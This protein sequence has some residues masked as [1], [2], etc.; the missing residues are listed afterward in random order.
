VNV[1]HI[2]GEGTGLFWVDE[3]MQLHKH[4]A[5]VVGTFTNRYIHNPSNHAFLGPHVIDTKGNVRTIEALKGHRLTATMDHLT[6]PQNRVYM[7]AMEGEFYE[8][9]VH[10]LEARQRFDLVKELDIPK[11]VQPHLKSAYTDDGRA[12]VWRT[13]PAAKAIISARRPLDGWPVGR[14]AVHD[15][16]VEA[17]CRGLRQERN[18]LCFR[19]SDPGDWMG[20]G[21]RTPEGVD[22]GD[23]A[24]VSP[25]ESR[26]GV[27]SRLEHGMDA[28][29][30][31]GSIDDL[32]EDGQAHRMGRG[33]VEEGCEG[34]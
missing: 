7:L 25:A 14:E 1:A 26:A 21:V 4:P 9:D 2:N 27:R 16:G 6:D 18:R 13:T 22:Q 28:D 8:V 17:I 3:K 33:V 23:M 10:T 20:Q 12:V 34:R 15:S 19:P 32:C 5:S 24:D 31:I 29:S 11:T 30:G